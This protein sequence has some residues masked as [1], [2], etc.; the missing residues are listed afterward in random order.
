MAI[1][2]QETLTEAFTNANGTFYF[3]DLS[4]GGSELDNPNTAAYVPCFFT[5]GAGIL[6]QLQGAGNGTLSMYAEGDYNTLLAS[7]TVEP[8]AGQEAYPVFMH[9]LA[10]IQSGSVLPLM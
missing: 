1:I 8:T 3:S 4:I 5:G 6:T 9:V 7:W 10:L 2:A